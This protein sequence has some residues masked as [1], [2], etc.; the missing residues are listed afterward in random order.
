MKKYSRSKL[1]ERSSSKR[2][3]EENKRGDG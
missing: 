3:K 1:V 2:E